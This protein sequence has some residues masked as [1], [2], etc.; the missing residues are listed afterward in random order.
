MQQPPPPL[1]PPPPQPHPV[2]AAYL[3]APT[4]TLA[5]VSLASGVLCWVVVP[6][7]GAIV[8]VV[9]GHLAKREIRRTGEQGDMLATVGLIL[10]YVH[11]VLVVGILLLLVVG[12]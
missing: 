3:P 8:A 9:T 6:V 7:I 12:L 2:P 5:I 11:L 4:N 1:Q 10:G